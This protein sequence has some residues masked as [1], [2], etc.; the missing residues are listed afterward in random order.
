ML[1]LIGFIL[2]G[3]I[4]LA[5][6]L[7]LF[8]PSAFFEWLGLMDEADSQLAYRRR[9]RRLQQRQG[10][11]RQSERQ[12]VAAGEAAFDQVDLDEDGQ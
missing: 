8:G 9:E 12:R 4:L 10:G 1:W 11:Q 7:W 6:L 3:L 2:G 5:A